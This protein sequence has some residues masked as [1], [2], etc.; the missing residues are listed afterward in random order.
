MIRIVAI[1]LGLLFVAAMLLLFYPDKNGSSLYSKV[2]LEV[3][4]SEIDLRK[5]RKIQ[6]APEVLMFDL[7]ASKRLW[8]IFVRGGGAV[9]EDKTLDFEVTLSVINRSED[10]MSLRI[11]SLTENETRT[12]MLGSGEE[13]T[14][15]TGDFNRLLRELS[16]SNLKK[17]EAG[18]IFA[19]WRSLLCVGSESDTRTKGELKIKSSS[20]VDLV[21]P[22]TLYMHMHP[23][24]F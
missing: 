7:Q 11:R 17:I 6:S 10:D 2:L 12:V 23:D 20:S 1:V 5:F 16:R 21:K 3:K 13:Y 8:T 9:A 15:Y 22:I 18:E 14:L 19:G 4:G 24:T